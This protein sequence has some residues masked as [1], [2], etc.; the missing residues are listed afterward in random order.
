[1]HDYLLFFIIFQIHFHVV[2]FVITAIVVV[3]IIADKVET[4][5]CD[6]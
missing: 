6:L 5:V 2:I 4:E 3:W 1:M